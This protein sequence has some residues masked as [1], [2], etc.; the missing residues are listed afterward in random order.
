MNDGQVIAF[1]LGGVT[2]LAAQ[3]VAFVGWLIYGGKGKRKGVRP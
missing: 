1:I 3:G 2:M